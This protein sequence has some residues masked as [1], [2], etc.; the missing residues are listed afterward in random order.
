MYMTRI[1]A[2]THSL[3]SLCSHLSSFW[4]V[5]DVSIS[6]VKTW[7]QIFQPQFGKTKKLLILN[8]NGV[9]CYFPKHVLLQ[10]DWQKT[11]KNLNISKLEICVGVHD[12]IS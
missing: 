12:F 9:F 3:I 6:N 4:W 8:V 5:H 10:G 11:R 2:F 7:I 1:D